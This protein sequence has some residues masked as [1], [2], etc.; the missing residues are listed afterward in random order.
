MQSFMTNPEIIVP[1]LLALSGFLLVSLAASRG[2][3][4]LQRIGLPL[5][6]GYL[7]VGLAA[8]PFALKLLSPE[9]I[10]K[11]RFVDEIALGFIAFAAGSEMH[12]ESIRQR[13]RSIAWM[14]TSL[15][16][17]TML[18][19]SSV[20]YFLAD[21]IPV[22]DQM[23]SS[24]R[25]GVAL[26][27]GAIT[28]ARSPSSA[29]ALVHELR[30]KGPLTQTTLGVTMLKDV[31][32][33]ILFAVA[34]SIAGALIHEVSFDIGFFGL[35]L[36]EISLAIGLGVLIGRFLAWQLALNVP[37][38]LKIVLIL[39]TGYGVYIFSHYIRHESPHIIDVEIL[40]E[41]LLMCMVAGFYV[42]NASKYST[43][44]GHLLHKVGPFV[45]IA[46]FTLTG[47]A[48]QVD[49][50]A[51]AWAIASLVFLVRLAAIF[52]GAYLGR[53]SCR[54]FQNNSR[55]LLGHLYHAGRHRP[56]FGQRSRCRIPGLGQCLRDDHDLGHRAQSARRS[57]ALQMG[58]S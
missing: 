40:L 27:A 28:V 49:V 38:R 14:T 33:I 35:L 2:A 39:A 13:W 20:F 3:E 41:P 55:H 17:F 36:A 31:V 57:T 23:P 6:S 50:L 22:I 56:G 4:G 1:V 47:A 53:G 34:S 10:Q 16:F 7:L 15:V 43:D 21:L 58:H 5:I 9:A 42:A 11:L 12:L 54:R 45:Y 52:I 30:A 46:F 37:E 19:V 48:L 26:L 24:H 44:F 51:Q 18:M 8:G 25:I 29:I 32:V